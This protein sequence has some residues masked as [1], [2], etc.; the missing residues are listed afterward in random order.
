[1]RLTT[2]KSISRLVGIWTFLLLL[3]FK[4]VFPKP[5]YAFL[6]SLDACAANPECAAAIGSELSPA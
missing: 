1:M 2:N 6:S 5:A 4:G 3:I